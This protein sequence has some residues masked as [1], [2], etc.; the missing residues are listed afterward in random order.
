MNVVT[1]KMEPF[2][3]RFGRFK[4]INIATESGV[5]SVTEAPVALFNAE[6]FP[7]DFSNGLYPE[8]L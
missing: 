2:D 4:I 3:P 8:Y 6:N 1:M 7:V 5:V